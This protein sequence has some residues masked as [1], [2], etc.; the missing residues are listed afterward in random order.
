VAMLYFTV[1]FC[2]ADGIWGA[3]DINSVMF[4][5]AKIHSSKKFA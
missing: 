5:G 2:R 1:I 3:I 4:A